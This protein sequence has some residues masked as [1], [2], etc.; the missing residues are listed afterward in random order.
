[1]FAPPEGEAQ[2]GERCI[3]YGIVVRRPLSSPCLRHPLREHDCHDLAPF[4][5]FVAVVLVIGSDA[6]PDKGE[7][8]SAITSP[9]CGSP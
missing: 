8:A 9:S 6:S 1:M 5:R 4:A 7:A 2:L 3:A